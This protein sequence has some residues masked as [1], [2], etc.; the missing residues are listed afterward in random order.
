MFY[1]Q[2]LLGLAV[3]AATF[4]PSLGMDHDAQELIDY[5][6]LAMDNSS[7]PIELLPEPTSNLRGRSLQTVPVPIG[8]DDWPPL[9]FAPGKVSKA[10]GRLWMNDGAGTKSFCTGTAILCGKPGRS[11]ILTAAHCL[12]SS[13]EVWFMPGSDDGGTDK[14]V[15]G[16]D[17]NARPTC[18][19]DPY[20]CWKPNA[21]YIDSR[22]FSATGRA[23]QNYDYA[24]LVVE[25]VGRH[26]E[27]REN[28]DPDLDNAVPAM[29]VDFTNEIRP[30]YWV[31]NPGVNDPHQKYCAGSTSFLAGLSQY[32]VV[33]CD[34]TQGASGG[35]AIADGN[36]KIYSVIS[37]GTTLG[38]THGDLEGQTL[39]R[40]PKLA[41]NSLSCLAYEANKQD[42]PDSYTLR[43]VDY[44]NDH[45]GK[46]CL[47]REY[48]WGSWGDPVQL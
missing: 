19:D 6:T 7:E 29:E 30:T 47:S 31:G 1:S 27:G 10:S 9:G 42:L 8:I 43:T 45:D 14:T 28:S 33:P 37:K 23:K 16:P 17:P 25:D 35:P 20:G 12:H 4:A 2:W 40:G 48:T 41:R 15:V 46:P 22:F 5:W 18:S 24:I 36:S 13:G 21:A 11:L 3:I 32:G 38:P 39:L 26:E 44:E 34:L